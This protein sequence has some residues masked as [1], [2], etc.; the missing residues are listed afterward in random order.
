MAT[1]YDH[2]SKDAV[3]QERWREAG[4]FTTSDDPL[5]ARPKRY[6][7]D[8]FPYPSGA[9]LHVGH[10]EGYT[11]TDI[12]SRYWRMKG[13]NVLHPMGWDAFGLPAENYAIKTGVHPKETTKQNTDNFRSQIQKAGLSYDWE[14]EIDTSSPEYYKW[15]QWF[16][17][18]LHGREL[19][20]RKLS[21][22]NWCES[23]KTVLANEQVLDGR[24]E[25]CD[26]EV[27]QKEQEQWFFKITEYAD[28][29]ISSLDTIDWPDGIKAMQENWVGRSEGARIRFAVADSS[30]VLEVFTTRPDT[31]FG[32]TFMALA[33]EHPMVKQFTT[34]EQQAEVEAYIEAT[35][36][37]SELERQA[38]DEKTGVF[39]GGFVMNPVNGEQVPVWIADYVLMGY[40]TGAI[41]AV[42]AHDERDNVFA[43]KYDLPIV[44]VIGGLEDPYAKEGG[45]LEHSDFLNGLDVK[46]GIQTAIE[47]IESNN[48]GV[49]ETTYKLRDWLISRQ[50][51]WGAPIPMVYDDQGDVYAL[52]EDELPVLLPEDVD[53]KPTGESPLVDSET[54]HAKEDMERIT[55]KLHDAGTLSSDR[56]IVRRESD[57]MDG[58][59]C[60]SWYMFR[61]TDPHNADAFAGKE[62][63]SRMMPVDLYVGGAEHA[64]LHLLYARF[65][66]M[67]LHDLG[68]VEFDEPFQA[69]RNP[70]IILAEDNR[71]MSKRWGNVVN[72][73]DVIAQHGADTLRMY[74][75]FVGPIEDSKPWSQSGVLGVRRFVDKVWGLFASGSLAAGET[76]SET[77]TL[78]HKT[79]KKVQ[80]DIE[81]FSFNTSVSAMMILANHLSEDPTVRV[82]QEVADVFLKVVS[83]FA[84]HL[85]ESCYEAIGGGGLVAMME[86]PQLDES[87]LQD[88]T[89]T[90]AF[91]VLGK[92]RGTFQV[93]PDATEEEA[94]A[95]AAQLP[96]YA[97]H[98]GNAELKKVIY[99]PR[100]ILNVIV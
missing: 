99:V 43:N 34:S 52:P 41:M 65:F 10:L 91:Q 68:Y 98:V 58:F 33:P 69:L 51:Y 5:D 79:L 15:T 95:I 88:E 37:K 87:A 92:T 93:A 73:D 80:E 3:W 35:T 28:R 63:L 21:K 46:S 47:W 4:A 8:M 89:V 82:T 78:L 9:G 22:V 62:A 42:P 36:K 18:L 6:I 25:R 2:T 44:N 17:L 85:A 70:G 29:L 71:K 14:R 32:V 26:T 84:P 31:L 67:V 56:T 77:R 24:C 45:L 96:G 76:P 12:V 66:T 11:A 94:L 23:C 64:V 49:R 53:F 90:I 86:W 20:E 27:V 1:P 16:F 13:E 75:M 19:A 60:S 38:S 81:G 97:Q 74:E 39:T 55:K 59:A 57:T 30:D 61:F 54:F 50:R 100:R 72:P 83:P 48:A 40:G 7:L